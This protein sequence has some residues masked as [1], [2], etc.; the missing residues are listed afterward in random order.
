[1]LS[2]Q[3]RDGKGKGLYKVGFQKPKEGLTRMD[4]RCREAMNKKQKKKKK[5][6]KAAEKKRAAALRNRS[7]TLNLDDREY[8]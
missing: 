3:L 2:V 5:K 4:L 1:V 8:Q 7:T 6:K